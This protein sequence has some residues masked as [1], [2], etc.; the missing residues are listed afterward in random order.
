ME[1]EPY[2]DNNEGGQIEEQQ[3]QQQV[4]AEE[5]GD[6]EP[7]AMQQTNQE[8]GS[9]DVGAAQNMMSSNQVSNSQLM[10]NNQNKLVQLNTG[11]FEDYLVQAL[12]DSLMKKNDIKCLRFESWWI[13]NGERNQ[14]SV[15]FRLDG[16]PHEIIIK[17]TKYY[18]KEIYSGEKK[19]HGQVVDCWD[20]YVG[21]KVDVFG[22]TTILK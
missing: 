22:K 5:L 4:P 20:L 3:E 2:Q 15:I 7:D 18:V 8:M 21:C 16:Q 14:I 13:E 1:A 10:M 11:R 12:N 19:N 17:D 6:Q 9:Q